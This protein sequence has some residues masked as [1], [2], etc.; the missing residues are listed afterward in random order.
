MSLQERGNFF[1]LGYCYVYLEP[2]APLCHVLVLIY[3][4][5]HLIFIFI[6]SF[7]LGALLTKLSAVASYLFFIYSYL[8]FFFFL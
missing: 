8:S 4:F 2:R 1:K 6:I 5:L 7:L 3:S